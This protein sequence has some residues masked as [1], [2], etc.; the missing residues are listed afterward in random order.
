M[1]FFLQDDDINLR[2]YLPS[3]I[4]PK[5]EE[6]S[7]WENVVALQGCHWS[8]DQVKSIQLSCHEM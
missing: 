8:Y 7:L 4:S 6:Y 3:Y 2:S 1:V 5:L